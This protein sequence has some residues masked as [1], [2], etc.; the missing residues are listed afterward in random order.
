MALLASSHAA[1]SADRFERETP[2]YYDHFDPGKVPWEPG[3]A[4]NI[5]EVFKDYQYYEIVLDRDGK[6]ITV[7]QYIRGAKSSSDKYLVMPD[8]ALQK[9]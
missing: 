1:S 8:G 3:Q 2:Y 5:E 9:Q 4:L 6:T 7:N